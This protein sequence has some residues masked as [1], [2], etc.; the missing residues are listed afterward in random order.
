MSNDDRNIRL[1]YRIIA[2]IYVVSWLGTLAWMG[3]MAVSSPQDTEVPS[4][5][6]LLLL[7]PIPAVL[8]GTPVW[9]AAWALFA[10]HQKGIGNVARKAGEIIGGLLA[11]GV[12]YV[13]CAYLLMWSAPTWTLG[14]RILYVAPVVEIAPR[15]HDCEF[16]TAPLGSKNCHYEANVDIVEGPP[17]RV[18]VSWVRFED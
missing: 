4:V 10:I 3:P 7:S 5:P 13:G 9:M 15:A 12:A 18:L 14:Y 2:G 11:L 17:M 1:G 8:L 6:M 16:S